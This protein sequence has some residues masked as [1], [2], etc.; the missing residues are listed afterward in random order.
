[1]I[2]YFGAIKRHTVCFIEGRVDIPFIDETLVSF[3]FIRP[4]CPF[5]RNSAWSDVFSQEEWIVIVGWYPYEDLHC[6]IT[7]L[8]RIWASPRNFYP[9]EAVFASALVF[10]LRKNFVFLLTPNKKGFHRLTVQLT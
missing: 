6:R 2:L 4:P 8:A 1:M 7:S 3:R 10:F 5:L 9:V